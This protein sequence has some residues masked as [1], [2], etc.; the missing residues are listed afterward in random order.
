MSNRIYRLLFGATLLVALYFDLAA[1][2]FGLILVALTE[3]LTNLRIP[4]VLSRIRYGEEGDPAEGCLGIN[5]TQRTTFEAERAWRLTVAA[6]L[7]ISIFLFPEALWFF[8]W[9]MGFAILG[10]GVSGVC[11]MFLGLKW[12]G[13]K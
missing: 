3:A 12:A 4:R 5:F 8:P 7:S 2:L 1:V 10:A 9:F 13:L 6:M 11:P